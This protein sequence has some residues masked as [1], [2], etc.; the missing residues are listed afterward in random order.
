MNSEEF[1]RVNKLENVFQAEKKIVCS[2]STRRSGSAWRKESAF[3]IYERN[4][5]RNKYRR[6]E[7]NRWWRWKLD[8]G[9]NMKGPRRHVEEFAFNSA[10]QYF[11]E[12]VTDDPGDLGKEGGSLE[13][14]EEWEEA[15][16]SGLRPCTPTHTTRASPISVSPFGPSY[17][18][19]FWQLF[20][21]GNNL[22]FA[23]KIAKIVRRVPTSSSSSFPQC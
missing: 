23:G 21:Y 13:G 22:R 18:Y 19:C 5:Y 11:P 9:E 7:V 8:K 14:S 15:E 10:G 3:K 20:L 2:K 4:K 12:Y 6:Q 1:L 16:H 17:Y